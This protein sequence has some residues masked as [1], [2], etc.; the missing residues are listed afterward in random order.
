MN[1]V[2]VKQLANMVGIP[3]ARLLAQLT[4]AGI[5]VGD[6]NATVSEK[7]KMQLLAYLRRSHGKAESVSGGG[8]SRVTLKRKTVRELR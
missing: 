5:R 1:E 3:V 4:D 6:E 7:E 2:T 8:P